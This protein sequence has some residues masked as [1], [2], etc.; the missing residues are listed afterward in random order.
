MARKRAFTLVELLAVIAIIVILAAIAVPNLA[1]AVEVA[2]RRLCANSLNVCAKG[3]HQYATSS[4]GWFPLV[5]LD[6]KNPHK[7][8]RV[9]QD[10][11]DSDDKGKGNSCNMFMLVR[12]ELVPQ[13]GFLCPSTDHEVNPLTDIHLDDDFGSI[14]DGTKVGGQGIHSYKTIS[15]S[16]HTQRRNNSSP[17]GA[18]KKEWRPITTVSPASMALMADRSPLSGVDSVTGCWTHGTGGTEGGWYPKLDLVPDRPKGGTDEFKNNSFNHNQKGQSVAYADAHVMWT[19]NPKAGI[20]EDNIWTWA[21][22]DSADPEVQEWG[23]T[24]E[25]LSEPFRF[26]CAA[27]SS[28]SMLWP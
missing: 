25:R 19:T 11:E 6:K 21:D 23:S 26:T 2:R 5:Y 17:G 28:D 15:Y 1:K 10:W 18:S 22:P 12:K 20:N 13:D 4:D 7:I 16:L 14:D 27:N 3:M 9:V 24:G 8:G